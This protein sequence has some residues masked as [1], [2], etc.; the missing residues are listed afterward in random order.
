MSAFA[1]TQACCGAARLGSVSEYID[2]GMRRA[3]ATPPEALATECT[4][5]A[6]R[7]ARFGVEL[8]SG[9]V[10]AVGFRASWCTT[11]I[12][13]CEVAAERVSGLPVAAAIRSLHPVDLARVLPSVPP[14]KRDRAQLAARALVTALLHSAQVPDR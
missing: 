8:R 12:A 9:I 5:Q 7:F 3:R 4:D 10:T 14:V 6:G 13:Y 2:R 1:S 11:L